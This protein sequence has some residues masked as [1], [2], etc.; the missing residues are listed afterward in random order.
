[1]EEEEG[2][3][4]VSI[5]PL[6]GPSPPSGGVLGVGGPF[7]NTQTQRGPTQQ[8]VIDQRGPVL[9]TLAWD[10]KGRGGAEV[11]SMDVGLAS[12]ISITF[13]FLRV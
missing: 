11:V 3:T 9:L 4:A 10:H 2:R 12:V 13:T 6:T 1:M 8:T 7:A 5:A